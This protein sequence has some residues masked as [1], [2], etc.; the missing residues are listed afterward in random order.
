MNC[1]KQS[2]CF[3]ADGP[4]MDCRDKNVHGL[5]NKRTNYIEK[6]AIFPTKKILA[7]NNAKIEQLK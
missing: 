3:Y 2:L 1:P 5:T 4:V 7:A 6:T